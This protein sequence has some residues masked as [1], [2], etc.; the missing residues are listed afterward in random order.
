MSI[1]ALEHN[2]QVEKELCEKYHIKNLREFA[3]S[4]SLSGLMKCVNC[5]K[6]PVTAG[7]VRFAE[8]QPE[9]IKC[10]ECQRI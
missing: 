6:F 4:N 9:L 7:N 8:Y 5:G 2:L 10:W 3:D 1:E